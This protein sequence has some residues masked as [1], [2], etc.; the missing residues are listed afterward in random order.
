MQ[1]K[2]WY[3]R[4]AALGLPRALN[5]LGQIH[6]TGGGGAKNFD[7]AKELFEKAA[8]LGDWA[9][10][11]NIGLLYLNGRG[12]ERDEAKARAWFAKAASLGDK[13]AQ[14]NLSRL[15]D[16]IRAGY[17]S[18]GM[19]ISARRTACV[20]SCQSIHRTYVASVCDK[21]FPTAPIEEGD[22]RKC[23]DLS[24][25]KSR[26]CMGSC[27]QGAGIREAKWV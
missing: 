8:A 1:A 25:G 26:Q 4:A 3:E 11:N 20:K 5:A 13:D 27:R 18:L 14:S 15:E 22:R 23:I 19:Q 10:M 12:V 7:L 17:P 6:L 21:Y 24:L 16:A 9:A 2:F